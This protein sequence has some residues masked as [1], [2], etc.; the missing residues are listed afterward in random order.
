MKSTTITAT[1]NATYK[2]HT[3][4]VLKEGTCK[5]GE[6]FC[7]VKDL[8]ARKN[9]YQIINLLLGNK[10]FHSLGAVGT[11][12]QANEWFGEYKKRYA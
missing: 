12:E 10:Y 9:K 3:F 2:I 1:N 7:L 8:K 6:S 11:E 4:E 5:N